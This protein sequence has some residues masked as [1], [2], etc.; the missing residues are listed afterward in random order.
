MIPWWFINDSLVNH[1]HFLYDSLVIPWWFLDDFL[2]IPWWFLN[3]SFLV[4]LQGRSAHQQSAA[5]GEEGRVIDLSQISDHSI[6][7]FHKILKPARILDWKWC[8]KKKIYLLVSFSGCQKDFI[9]LIC[10]DICDSDLLPPGR[11]LCFPI[12]VH[13]NFLLELVNVWGELFQS[14]FENA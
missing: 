3:D 5:K 7:N 13:H 10:F 4:I 2:M 8:T 1:G 6:C 9:F 12:G 11:M 14:V